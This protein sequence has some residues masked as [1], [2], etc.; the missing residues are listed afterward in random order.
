MDLEDYQ[1]VFAAGTLVLMLLIASPALSLS[2]NFQNGA[3]KFSEFWILGPNHTLGDYPFN[4]QANENYQAFVG[5][6]NHLG[7]DSYYRV[8]IKFRS[9]TQPFLNNSEPS[10]LPPLHEYQFFVAD[11]GT[12]ES[13]LSFSVSGV[14]IT[15][16]TSLVRDISIDGVVFPVDSESP[17]SHEHRGYYYQ[18]LFELWLYNMTSKSFHYH[19]RFVGLW[20]NMTV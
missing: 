17:W 10:S 4:I 8:Y 13:S 2:V 16:N 1:I 5:V 9:L 12:W 6:G 14:S 7:Q 18:M 3:A 19:N 20:L 11:E 15:N